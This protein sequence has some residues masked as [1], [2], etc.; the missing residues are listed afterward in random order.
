ML[1]KERN[2][3][4][5]RRICRSNQ[6]G[7]M[8]LEE[9]KEGFE[10]LSIVMRVEDIELVFYGMDPD[11]SGMLSCE[12]FVSAI[13]THERARRRRAEAMRGR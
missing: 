6:G 2:F 3:D 11:G 4:S 9:L 1:K 8:T 13:S 10:R 5:S 12:E 7:T